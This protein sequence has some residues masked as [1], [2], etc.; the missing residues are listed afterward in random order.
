L[1]LAEDTT[2]ISARAS[3]RLTS[4]LVNGREFQMA[5]FQEKQSIMVRVLFTLMPLP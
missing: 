2:I 1:C 4:V 3:M 5:T